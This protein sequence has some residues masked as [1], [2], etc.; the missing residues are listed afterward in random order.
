MLSR[1]QQEFALDF[2]EVDITAD[3]AYWERY[4]HEI[5]VLVIDDAVELEAPIRESEVRAVLREKR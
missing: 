2:T 4:R 3:A 1:L 5:P